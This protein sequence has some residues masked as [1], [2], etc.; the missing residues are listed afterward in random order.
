MSFF[1]KWYYSISLFTDLFIAKIGAFISVIWLIIIGEWQLVLWLF[2]IGFIFSFIYKMI[3][4][5]VFRTILP[6]FKLNNKIISKLLTSLFVLFILV[7]SVVWLYFVLYYVIDYLL[8]TNINQA[9]ILIM[10]FTL[11]KS[12][13][14]KNDGYIREDNELNAANNFFI[15]FSFIA[16]I[17]S[18]YYGDLLIGILLAFIAFLSV[19]VYGI[20][21]IIK[22]EIDNL[23]RKTHSTSQI[24]TSE[25][26]F[27]D[28]SKNNE[29]KSIDNNIKDDLEIQAASKDYLIRAKVAQSNKA[30]V[31]IL[32]QLSN[33][34]KAYVRE[35]VAGNSRTPLETLIK[36]SKD[37]KKIV[38]QAVA[39]NSVIK[40]LIKNK[41][42]Y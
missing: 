18:F 39:R 20:L 37:D 21:L 17:I 29:N 38:R 6:A 7:L 35:M 10:G 26:L 4:S 3:I 34:K 28:Y 19:C 14:L 40:G 36:L 41:D 9:I 33:D 5:I 15:E 25:R 8:F 2:A 42:F 30:S 31:K 32:N 27:E 11:L 23:S 24:N 12:L 13:F 1:E 16:I 22:M